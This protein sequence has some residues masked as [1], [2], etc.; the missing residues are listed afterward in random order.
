MADFTSKF[1]PIFL[2]DQFVLLVSVVALA[3]AVP[4]PLPSLGFSQQTDMPTSLP[5][6]VTF[7][8]DLFDP[9]SLLSLLSMIEWLGKDLS[10]LAVSTSSLPTHHLL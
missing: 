9:I 6:G 10:T 8:L 2:F 5:Q 3:T 7:S 1:P 4:F